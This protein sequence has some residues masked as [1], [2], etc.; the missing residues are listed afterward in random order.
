MKC[1][2]LLMLVAT[3]V[4]AEPWSWRPELSAAGVSDP[5]VIEVMDQVR[6]ADFLPK[7]QV[8]HAN[9][10]RPLPIGHGQTTSQPTLIALM[11]QYARLKP[12]CRVLEVGTGSGYQTAMLAKLCAQVQSVDIVKP[13]VDEAK[14]RLAGYPNV[15]VRAGD[16]YLGWPERAPF[17][18]IIVCASADS[19][20]EP[21]LAQLKNGG[22]LVIPIGDPLDSELFVFEKDQAGKVS[23]VSVLP[24]R[25]VPLIRERP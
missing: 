1:L 10:D 18:A 9:D 6:R 22:R 12:G 17:D 4:H 2:W 19:V 23:Q 13:L 16:G 25:F 15:E 7:A 20:P 24:V 8:K 5:R 14:K 11:M 21:L 3:F